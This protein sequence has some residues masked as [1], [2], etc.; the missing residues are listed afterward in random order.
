MKKTLIA[1][2]LFLL[3]SLPALAAQKTVALSVPGMTCSACPITV[4]VALNRVEG[5]SSVDVR[6][7]GRE[8]MVTFDDTKTSVEALTQA[9]TN[10]GYPST[11]KQTGAKQE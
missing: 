4:K 1:T 9:T 10:A 5:V 7:E 11:L 6:Y 8:A 2:A 3:F